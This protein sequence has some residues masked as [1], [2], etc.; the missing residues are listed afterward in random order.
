VAVG[1]AAVLGG[2]WVVIG[3][4]KIKTGYLLLQS[5]VFQTII[6]MPDVYVDLSNYQ[7]EGLMLGLFA[8][9]CIGTL[10]CGQS[11]LLRVAAMLGL[12]AA[13]YLILIV[14]S[15]ASILG[16]FA[17][18]FLSGI[19][20][21][22]WKSLPAYLVIAIALI[23]V[24]VAMSAVLEQLR[25]ADAGPVGIRR[26]I[27]GSDIEHDPTKRLFLFRTA[28][29]MLLHDHWIFLFGGGAGSFTRL[30][31]MPGWYPHN[32]ILELLAEY[33]VVGT[34]LFAAWIVRLAL[35]PRWPGKYGTGGG[36]SAISSLALATFFWMTGMFTGALWNSWMLIF[37]TTLFLGWKPLLQERA[38]TST[39]G[40]DAPGAIG[41][42]RAL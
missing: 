30:I 36:T 17:A 22:G 15:R 6:D 14:G 11:F 18:L 19:R 26:F 33:G 13:S 42:S 23:A 8:A 37:F 35:P 2:V 7:G 4:W 20:R 25:Y 34:T 24:A 1:V 27:W 12:I 32:L 9:F 10:F 41:V 40:G 31:G 3:L 29:D 28:L 39:T 5:D 21:W 16:V 38:T